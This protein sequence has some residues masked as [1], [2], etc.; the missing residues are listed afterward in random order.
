MDP[1]STKF[2]EALAVGKIVIHPQLSHYLHTSAFWASELSRASTDGFREPIINLCSVLRALL[3]L[4]HRII[5]WFGG[6]THLIPVQGGL[7][8]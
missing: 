2:N 5:R 6:S 1:N 3:D 8:C 4:N 7:T